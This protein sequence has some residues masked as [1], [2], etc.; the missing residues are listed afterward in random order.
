M[1]VVLASDVD[2]LGRIGDTKDVKDGFAL[3]W[4]IPQGLAVPFGTRA[5]RKL[6]SKRLWFD[7]KAA[8]TKETVNEQSQL[9]SKSELRQRERAKQDSRKVVQLRPKESEPK[10]RE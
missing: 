8:A 4:L 10:R 5:A 9:P 3:H 6:T 7:G 1:K 2:K